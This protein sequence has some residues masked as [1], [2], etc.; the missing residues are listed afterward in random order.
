MDEDC[1]YLNIWT[2][3]VSAEEKLPVMFFIHGGGFRSGYSYEIYENGDAYGRNG[4]ILIKFDYRLGCLGYMAH[5]LLTGESEHHASG[6][7]GLLDQIAALKWVRRNI[8]A[9]G[10]DPDNI[11]I[12][13]QSAGSVSVLNM[14]TSPLTE[15]D[16][17]KAIMQSGGG[18]RRA[19]G[20]DTAGHACMVRLYGKAE[21]PP[22]QLSILL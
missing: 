12:S 9:F 14:V 8:A 19:V 16:I 11:T 10:G 17:A 15:G 2:P 5:P 18:A 21:G 4:V 22:S 20:Y 6:N 13:G 7:Y 1:L 3:A